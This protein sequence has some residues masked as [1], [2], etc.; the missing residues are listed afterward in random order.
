MKITKRLVTV[1]L[2]LM[3]VFAL[4]APA[5]AMSDTSASYTQVALTNAPT[6]TGT[7]TI[8]LSIDS[9]N[10]YNNNTEDEYEIHRYKLPVT[11]GTAGVTKTYYVSDVLVEAMN[12][13]PALSFTDSSGNEIIS[14]SSY[15][16]GVTDSDVDST[17]SFHPLTDIN[18]RNGWM[19]RID[20]KYPILNSADWISGWTSANG[21]CGA[22]IN[23]AYLTQSG[24]TI[25]FYF[26]DASSSALATKTVCID[27]HSYDS[28]AKKLTL[29]FYQSNSWYDS[30]TNYWNINN[31]SV[32]ASSSIWVKID[33]GSMRT[34]STNAS[35][36]A[37]I[38]N[39]TLSSGSHTITILPQ[40]NNYINGSYTYGILKN[41]QLE[42]YTF[43]V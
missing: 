22:A 31:Y 37:T 18:Y 42:K 11:M 9:S 13:Y 10:I 36:Q 2:A 26:A 12:D 40:Y 4:A 5:M 41:V 28:S 43:A 30:A 34:L 15:V 35:G 32:L 38:S 24:Q 25:E 3:L 8:Y 7:F 20:G 19:F 14:T 29:T 27:S 39:I 17:I 1:V 16:Y 23:Q 6:I 33:N 21:P